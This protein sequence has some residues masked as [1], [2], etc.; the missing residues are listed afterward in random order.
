M[1]YCLPL[2]HRKSSSID[3][4]IDAHRESY[5]FFEIWLDLLED[6]TSEWLITTARTLGEKGIFLLRRPLLETPYFDGTLRKEILK[7]LSRTSCFI[8]IDIFSQGEDLSFYHSISKD[9]PTVSPRSSLIA[10][11]HNYTMTPSLEE[12]EEIL[13][14][15]LAAT[16]YVVK[17]STYCISERDA[18]T[19]L[20]LGLTLRDRGRPYIVLGMGPFG[21]VTRVFGSLW[22]N[23]C[24]FA[25]VYL[26]N[27]SAPGQLTLMQ[28]HQIMELL[29]G[30]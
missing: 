12:L 25:P 21:Q 4:A 26:K 19:L 11:Y 28:Y 7:E 17:I 24:I 14:S 1:K 23:F 27:I 2:Q 5:D 13:T 10:S 18:L 3:A 15:L 22:G 30:R 9:D 16:P 20:S 29:D 6:F 8:D